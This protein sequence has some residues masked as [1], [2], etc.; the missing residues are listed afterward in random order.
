MNIFGRPI[1]KCLLAPLEFRHYRAFAA[2]F[3]VYRNP[4]IEIRRYLTGAGAYPRVISV[5]SPA[6]WID[7]TL[8]SHHDLLTVNE[9]FCRG[10]YRSGASASVILDLGANI[11]ISAAYFLSRNPKAFIHLYEPVERNRDRLHANLAPFTGRY[12]VHAQA[13]SLT[14]GTANFG[15]DQTGRYGGIDRVF[16]ESFSVEC[17]DVRDVVDAT[18]E[19]HGRIDILKI[20]VERLRPDQAARIG[21]ILIEAYPMRNPLAAS[22]AWR[23]YG[24]IAQFSP[25][26]ATAA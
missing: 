5:R 6:G 22:H 26:T 13:V 8:Y 4:L 7:L 1:S 11:G 23:Q 3:R 18:L 21:T 15:V 25:I 2:A 14:N 17:L 9:I 12:A 10:D 24:P 20:D 19:H 16:D